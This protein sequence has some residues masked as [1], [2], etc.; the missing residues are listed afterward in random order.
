MQRLF[1]LSPFP[2]YYQ[3]PNPARDTIHLMQ[4]FYNVGRVDNGVLYHNIQWLGTN[5]VYIFHGMCCTGS[6][7]GSESIP[8]AD[9][10][11]PP[12]LQPHSSRHSTRSILF[13]SVVDPHSLSV[14]VRIQHFFVNADPDTDPD[15]DLGF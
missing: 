10:V 8:G 15:P 11:A 12:P 9:E 2:L 1:R 13:S 14:R 4:N 7:G 5:L 3:K 6:E